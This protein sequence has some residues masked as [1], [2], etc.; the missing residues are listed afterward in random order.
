MFV[1]KINSSVLNVYQNQM[2]KTIRFSTVGFGR[3]DFSYFF[4]TK[5]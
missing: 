1:S 3:Y 5:D 4:N 2:I